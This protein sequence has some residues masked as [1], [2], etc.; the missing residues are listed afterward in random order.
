MSVLLIPLN[1]AIHVYFPLV[2]AFSVY[3]S[4][5]LFSASKSLSNLLFFSSQVE[6]S[7][8]PASFF[9]ISLLFHLLFFSHQGRHCISAFTRCKMQLEEHLPHFVH[10]HRLLVEQP[11]NIEQHSQL[12]LLYWRRNILYERVG[13]RGICLKRFLIILIRNALHSFSIQTQK[14]NFFLLSS[15]RNILSAAN[16]IF[17]LE[18]STWFGY[19][20]YSV[21]T[22]LITELALLE[23]SA[24]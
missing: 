1:F 18:M 22:S 12:W 3:S 23:T 16:P 5:E 13:Q 7:Q 9:Q 19:F 2:S 11:A 10:G 8:V 24:K 17:T 15:S 20:F 21:F 4:A 14:P 6:I